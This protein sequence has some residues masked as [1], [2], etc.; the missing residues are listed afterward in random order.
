M[1]EELEERVFSI[2]R[3]RHECYNE[4]SSISE[5]KKQLNV[6]SHLKAE[7]KLRWGWVLWMANETT[8]LQHKIVTLL[9]HFAANSMVT[10]HNL[11]QFWA[12]VKV[13]GRLHYLSTSHQP[14]H[15]S[16]PCKGICWYRKQCMD[17]VYCVDVEGAE[18]QE[19]LGGVGRAYLRRKPESTRDLRLYSTSEFPALLRDEAASCGFCCYLA[20]PLFDFHKNQCYGVLE[21]LSRENFVIMKNLPPTL[22]QELLQIT[23]LRSTHINFIPISRWP[24]EM[25]D[26]YKE[27]PVC[28]IREIL[29]L[30]IK[31]VPRLSLAQVW[32]PCKQCADLCCME[33]SAFIT[34]QDKI[35]NVYEH[36]DSDLL[37]YLEACE[38]HNLQVDLNYFRQT[39]IDLSISRNPLA[40]YAKKARLSLC[41]AI[42]LQSVNNS[43]GPN[44][45]ILEFLLQPKCGEDSFSD[46]SMHLLLRIIEIKLKS[47]KFVLTEHLP[48]ELV[49]QS[50]QPNAIEC[51]NN[52]LNVVNFSESNFKGYLETADIC[53]LRPS[54]KTS[55]KG[56]VFGWPARKN[57]S[58]NDSNSLLTTKIV[59]FMK[60]IAV[61]F[62]TDNNW[63]VQFWEPKIVKDRCYLETSGQPYAL[64]CLAEGLASFRKKCIEHHYFVDDEAKEEEL[65]P[66]GRVFR[67]GHPEITPNLFLYSTKEFPIRNYAVQCFLQQYFALPVFD[68]HK[69]VGVLEV[70]GFEYVDLKKIE[71]ALKAAKLCSTH[72]DFHPIFL[73][74]KEAVKT[75]NGRRKALIE[76][77]KALE[78]ITKIPQLHMV[79]VWVPK[80]ECFSS[81]SNVSCM[82]LALSTK[83]LW[84]FMPTNQVHCIHVQTRKG[85]VGMVL[86]SENKS[87]FC[88]NLCEFSIVDQPLSHY[89]M[90]EKRDVCCFAICLE[91][92]HTRDLLY[93]IEFFLYQGPSTYENLLSFLNFLLPI[94]KRELKSFKI[95]SGKQIGD[96]ELVVEVIEFS[97][98]NKPT[99][100]EPDLQSNVFPVKFKSV[101]YSK[102]EY[103][104]IEEPQLQSDSYAT[105][106]E[107][108]SSSASD[109]FKR[110]EKGKG[111]RKTSLHLSREVLE[112]H[113]GKK[114]DDV[115]EELGVGKSTIKRACRDCGISRWPFNEKHARNPSL[116]ERESDRD[117]QQDIRATNNRGSLR[118]LHTSP[119]ENVQEEVEKVMIKVKY[120]EEKI[121]FELC[122]PIGVSR[123]SEEVTRRLNL[124]RGSFKLKYVDE[125]N[126]EILITCDDDLQLCPK[127]KTATG[128]L[129]SENPQI[130]QSPAAPSFRLTP[131]PSPA[132]SLH[133]PQAQ[134]SLP[135]SSRLPE[136]DF[137][138]PRPSP[139]PAGDS[140][141][142]CQAS[143]DLPPP[144]TPSIST[145][146]TTD[147]PPLSLPPP[148]APTSPPASPQHSQAHSHLITTS[149]ISHL[150]S[151]I[152]TLPPSMAASPPPPLMVVDFPKTH[153]LNPQ[154]PLASAPSQIDPLPPTHISIIFGKGFPA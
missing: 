71:R 119:N 132:T 131:F 146:L 90:S 69:Y 92:S 31:A 124:K 141:H 127:S 151:A 104:N 3:G 8:Q 115:A 116:F 100:S 88:R 13:E 11:V 4:Y 38:L 94:M 40:H 1:N 59:Q 56:W 85:I 121:R 55:H 44:F 18:Y 106:R 154:P 153:L 87:C 110:S 68:E 117:L 63:I 111:K 27:Q 93:V 48:D 23:G 36:I 126:E 144:R 21:I 72:I 99:S 113:F 107:Q 24:T 32:V 52:M 17:H 67:N 30:A 26:K 120:K 10:F 118:L 122:L 112:P 81:N 89:D 137:L 135:A 148:A 34:A 101:Q 47:F 128:T 29:E 70:I 22:D 140:I 50:R 20:L 16:R 125:D 114:L 54:Y 78:L 134:T 74:N 145:Q 42:C 139:V 65:G 108:C 5:F 15:V 149:S 102:K 6:V 14:F 19:Q 143:S 150:S 12:V 91:S 43:N 142:P 83:A 136:P 62:W 28:E 45:V 95:A 25:P 152:L 49:G 57:L 51:I 79:N 7:E 82:E 37:E 86:A 98:A 130:P 147:L 103:Q 2:I 53:C 105:H 66:P 60:K 96:E 80:G 73:S 41:F 123:I 84:K 129:I 58:E 109:N 46:S 64:G 97:E 138:Q 76:V 35:V 61:K 33:R 133:P 77:K 9:K 75:I 39:V